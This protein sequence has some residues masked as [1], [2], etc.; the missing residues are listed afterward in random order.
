MH[1]SHLHPFTR[2]AVLTTLLLIAHIVQIGCTVHPV[3]AASKGTKL[4]GDWRLEKVQAAGAASASVEYDVFYLRF[5]EEGWTGC[6][7]G[8]TWPQPRGYRFDE[9]VG[10]LTLLDQEGRPADAFLQVQV[11]DETFAYTVDDDSAAPDAEWV[12]YTYRRIKLK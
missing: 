4:E 10:I 6:F 7:E 3:D 12:R 1:P 11:D 2:V 5:D 8:Q 9:E